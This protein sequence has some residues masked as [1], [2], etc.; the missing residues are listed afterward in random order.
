MLPL[1]PCFLYLYITGH[2][3]P[4]IIPCWM[5]GPDIFHRVI[6]CHGLQQGSSPVVAFQ[7]SLTV[8]NRNVLFLCGWHFVSWCP[9]FAD[10]CPQSV[11]SIRSRFPRLEDRITAAGNQIQ[12]DDYPRCLSDSSP[13]RQPRPAKWD[14]WCFH[15]SVVYSVR[16]ERLKWPQMFA[17]N[18]KSEAFLF[19]LLND[20]GMTLMTT[21][22]VVTL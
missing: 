5:I 4:H 9:V 13:A 21:M 20:V 6:C 22:H 1:N 17:H 2:I 8:R 15:G 10:T 16:C 3:S 12:L 14:T 7:S 18:N 11:V 19:I